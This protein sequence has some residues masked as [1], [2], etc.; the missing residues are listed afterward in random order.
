MTEPGVT[1]ADADTTGITVDASVSRFFADPD[2]LKNSMSCTFRR[3]ADDPTKFVV[4]TV[5]E[6]LNDRKKRHKVLESTF[7]HCDCLHQLVELRRQKRY[8]QE[9]NA[10]ALQYGGE[11][12][13]QK[14]NVNKHI[15]NVRS[16][17]SYLPNLGR[18]LTPPTS[19]AQKKKK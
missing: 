10:V 19:R 5:I 13:F 2:A 11:S 15:K 6:P 3:D 17:K 12:S 14:P 9:F 4:T 18:T 8:Q 16:Q 1:I 7:E